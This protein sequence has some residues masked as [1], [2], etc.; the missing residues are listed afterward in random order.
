MNR[1]VALLSQHQLSSLVATGVDYCVMILCVSVLGLSPVVAVGLWFFFYRTRWGMLVRA[2]TV[3]REM[4]GALGVDVSKLY[5]QVFIF[6]SWLAGLGE[7]R[8]YGVLLRHQKTPANEN[9]QARAEEVR[10]GGA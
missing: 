6:G 3:D 9:Q 8:R 4:L 10:S 2:A 7:Q 1:T 5:T